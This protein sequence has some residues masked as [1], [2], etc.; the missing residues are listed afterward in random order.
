MYNGRSLLDRLTQENTNNNWSPSST[1]PQLEPEEQSTISSSLPV[2][3]WLATIYDQADIKA[4]GCFTKDHN[5]PHKSSTKCYLDRGVPSSET[6]FATAILRGDY[7]MS[8]AAYV[9]SLY[10][11]RRH[12]LLV[13][14]TTTKSGWG[15]RK[16]SLALYQS[17]CNCRKSFTI[18]ALDC[19]PDRQTVGRH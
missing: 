11:H 18:I 19:Y 17:C 15:W 4:A 6:P 7:I 8:R 5:K 3:T 13:D 10:D 2:C 14:V 1:W 16:P 12:L 9:K